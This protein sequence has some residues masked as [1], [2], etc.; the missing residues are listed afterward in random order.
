MTVPPLRAAA[1]ATAALVAVGCGGSAYEYRSAPSGSGGG[2]RAESV[3]STV[4]DGPPPAPEP[5]ALEAADSGGLGGGDWDDWEPA[6]EMEQSVRRAEAQGEARARYTQAN[7]GG[8]D[9]GGS[10]QGTPP[11]GSG[12]GDDGGE[13]ATD[14]VDTSG[15]LLI[16]TAELHLAVYEVERT[17]EEVLGAIDELDGFLARRSD[18]TIVVRVPAARFEEALEAIEGAGDVLHRNIEVQDV[19]EEFRDLAIRIR[20]AE[21]M[22]DRLEQLLQRAES[23]EDALEI[24]RELQR[25]TDFIERMKGRQRFL[26]DRIAFSTITIQ[27][28][29]RATEQPPTDEFRLP[30]DW[31]NELGV[32]RLLSL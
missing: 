16:Y 9:D 2:G 12:G 26:A 13:T 15:P 27:F 20:N 25:L 23:V 19:S 10:P 31:L 30:F 17:Q 29:S 8:E 32:T 6:G 5:V 11:S 21:A 18:T 22:R 3:A 14:A 7:T 24:E 28:S 4:A 1:L